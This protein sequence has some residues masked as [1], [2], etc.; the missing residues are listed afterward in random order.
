MKYPLSVILCLGVIFSVAQKKNSS[1]QLH[2]RKT[3]GKIVIDGI[4]NETDWDKAETARNFFMVLPMDTS[5]AAVRTDVKLTYDDKNIYIVAI[6]YLPK[7]GPYMVESLRRDFSFVKNDN[8]IFF[9]DT[10]NDLTSGYT[11]G[12]NAAGALMGWHFV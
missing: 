6:C 11:F 4:M 10:Y 1:F 7:K 2:I 12:A 3:T 8:F 5:K 9:L